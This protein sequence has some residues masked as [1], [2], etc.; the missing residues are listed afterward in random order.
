MSTEER[1]EKLRETALQTRRSVEKKGEEMLQAPELKF[2]CS[3][4]YRPWW[5]SCPLAACGHPRVCRDSPAAHV[6]DTLE[7]GDVQRR[8]QHCGGTS[9]LCPRD[10]TLWTGSI[11]EQS[12]KSCRLWEGSM[13]EKEDWRTVFHGRGPHAG[14]G[15]ELL[16]LRWNNGQNNMRWTDYNP[17]SPVSLCCWQGGGKEPGM[18]LSLGRREEW[19]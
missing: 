10:C 7:Q 13:L 1:S 16:F 6:G 4:G 19:G 18:K 15:E 17:H 11:L 8:L 2:P 12:V 5:S 14:T 3:L 9:S